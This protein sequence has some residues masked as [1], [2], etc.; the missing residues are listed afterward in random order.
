MLRQCPTGQRSAFVI[1]VF[2]S[3]PENVI[4]RAVQPS[5]ARTDWDLLKSVGLGLEK[6]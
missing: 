1:C 3:M 2:E 4:G 5:W 6:Q